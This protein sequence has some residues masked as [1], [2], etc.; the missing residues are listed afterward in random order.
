[1]SKQ[2]KKTAADMSSET[3]KKCL[4]CEKKSKARG[5]CTKHLAAYDRAIEAKFKATKTPIEELEKLAIKAG[6]ILPASKSGGRP[7]KN[8]PK[9]VDPMVELLKEVW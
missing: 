3:G 2:K 6:A 5:L 1:M 9:K 8:A 4:H 7:R